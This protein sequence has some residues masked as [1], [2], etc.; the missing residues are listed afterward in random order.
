MSWQFC[1]KLMYW[2]L[3]KEEEPW[4]PN[5]FLRFIVLHL[6]FLRRVKK[7]QQTGLWNFHPR[8]K[9]EVLLLL[10]SITIRKAEVVAMHD[11]VREAIQKHLKKSNR[12]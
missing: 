5:K 12:F 3:S 7:G 4:L 10:C 9:L 1:R 6:N 8:H 2:T 11:A